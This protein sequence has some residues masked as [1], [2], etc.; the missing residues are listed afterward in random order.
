LL[1]SERLSQLLNKL[2]VDYDF[3]IIDAPPLIVS[4]PLSIARLADQVLLIVGG[5]AV[6]D[7]DLQAATRQL[8]GVGVNHVSIVVN[9]W[10]GHEVAY[11]YLPD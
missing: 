10:R 8:S 9:R 7:R 11:D 5:Q 6:P 4:D 2:R 3:V 1:A